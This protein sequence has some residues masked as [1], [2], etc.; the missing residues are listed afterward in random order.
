MTP[1]PTMAEDGHAR[2][3]DGHASDRRRPATV[4]PLV[5]GKLGKGRSVDPDIVS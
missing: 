3:E 5:A 2:A 4:R 1:P